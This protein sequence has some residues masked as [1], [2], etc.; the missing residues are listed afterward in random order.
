MTG[1]T[2]KFNASRK[3]TPRSSEKGDVQP[4]HSYYPG[5]DVATAQEG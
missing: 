4:Q 1:Q 3:E 5:T 2:E